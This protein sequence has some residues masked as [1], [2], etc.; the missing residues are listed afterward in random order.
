MKV[1]LV[2]NYY[3]QPGGEDL[4]FQDEADLLAEKGHQVFRY[5]LHNDAVRNLHQ[6]E[7]FKA[8]IWNSAVYRRL[9]E[10]IESERIEICH[11]HNTFPLVSPA[12]Y[13]AAKSAG[14]AVIQTLHNYRLLCPAAT[15]YRDGKVCQE[16]LTKRVPWPSVMHACYRDSRVTTSVLAAMLVQHRL[17]GTWTDAVDRYI[18]LTD[19]SRNKFVEGGFPAEKVVV[20]KNF[21]ARDPEVGTGDGQFALYI[22]RLVPEKGVMT[23]L[24][25]WKSLGS[26]IPLKI[27]GGGPI[28]DLVTRT[29]N[30]VPGVEYLGRVPD[31]ELDRL[32]GQAT[33][34]VFP[35]EWFE[36][37]PRTILESYAK[38]T[39]VI[40]SDLGSMTDLIDSGRTGFLFQP[41]NVEDLVSTVSRA[42][43]QPEQLRQMRHD[44]RH[45]FESRYTAAQNYTELMA[46]Y[47]QAI[48]PPAAD[49]IGVS[50]S[51]QVGPQL[52]Q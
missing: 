9:R 15:F 7:L 34:L 12:G 4:A 8:T 23:M 18:A 14:A 39:P 29:A 33:F 44:A 38:G 30:D 48:T 11:F 46:I 52:Q 42:I 22:G 35:S 51:P 6:I 40:A 25:A 3:Q 24:A 50:V 47:R 31:G 16:C 45:E 26:K 27:I 28:A 13:Y 21:L 36:G 1:L 49:Q 41:G 37:M 19:F 5:S 20:K 32:L 43:A 2:H 10:M 17:R